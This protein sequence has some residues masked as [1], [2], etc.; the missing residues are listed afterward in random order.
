MVVKVLFVTPSNAPAGYLL[1]FSGQTSSLE[2][3]ALKS[4]AQRFIDEISADDQR[5]ALMRARTAGGRPVALAV[6]VEDG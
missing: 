1:S 6:H 3:V 2:L 5:A 4:D